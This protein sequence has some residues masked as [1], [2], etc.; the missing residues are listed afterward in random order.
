MRVAQ[1]R[2]TL[3][4]GMGWE[5]C[6]VVTDLTLPSCRKLLCELY[7]SVSVDAKA[8]DI[9]RHSNGLFRYR[10]CKTGGLRYDPCP[11]ATRSDRME[12]DRNR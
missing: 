3:T 8:C 1:R 6:L 10:N 12:I 11:D 9:K 2:P 4:A 5:S 7:E